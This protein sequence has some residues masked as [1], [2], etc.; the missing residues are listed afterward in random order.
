[1][2]SETKE[3]TKL[4]YAIVGSRG[5]GKTTFAKKHFKEARCFEG[6]SDYSCN[7][8]QNH[9]IIVF[10]VQS[11]WEIPADFLKHISGWYCFQNAD[12]KINLNT[13]N[14]TIGEYIYV[15]KIKLPKLIIVVG[16]TASGKTTFAENFFPHITR[17]DIDCDFE[18]HQFGRRRLRELLELVLMVRSVKEIPEDLIPF[19]E[20]YYCFRNS[21]YGN[22]DTSQLKIGDFVCV[23]AAN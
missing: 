14:L 16:E 6:M 21:D 23:A 1:M 8:V 20:R 9:E 10:I 2:Q 22:V 7:D 18:V 19:I 4:Y 17:C 3:I 5:S 12:C 11:M 13:K 15:E